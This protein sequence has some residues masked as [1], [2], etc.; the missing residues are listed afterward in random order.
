MD[1][2]SQKQKRQDNTLSSLNAAIDAMNLAKEVS[3][4]TPAKVVFGTVSIILTMIRVRFPL[5]SDGLF[6]FFTLLG[7][8]GEQIRLCRTRAGLR[9]CMQSPSPWDGR[10]EA[11]GP[12]SV[13]ARGD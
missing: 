5:P 6:Q 3:G 2:K 8:D 13:R 9:Q 10:E 7:L 4:A 1:P 12:Q 11:G